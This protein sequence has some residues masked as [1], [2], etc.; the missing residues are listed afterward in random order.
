ME[1]PT[2][3]VLSALEAIAPGAVAQAA[4]TGSSSVPEPGTALILAP[5][6]QISIRLEYVLARLVAS[7]V[8]RGDSKLMIT[9]VNRVRSRM[10][11]EPGT[12]V[13]KIF[14]IQWEPTLFDGSPAAKAT[15][16]IIG[17][18]GRPRDVRVRPEFEL[19]VQFQRLKKDA[20]RWVSGDAFHVILLAPERER[21]EEGTAVEIGLAP[22][23]ELEEFNRLSEADPIPSLPHSI[24]RIGQRR[25]V[26]T[27]TH[28]E[29]RKFGKDKE[30]VTQ[31]F[32]G[33]Y[34]SVMM[35]MDPHSAPP[36]YVA[37]PKDEE[38]RPTIK[39]YKPN[40]ISYV[41]KGPKS[42]EVKFLGK[43]GDVPLDDG[44]VPTLAGTPDFDPWAALGHSPTRI[45]F[46]K[47]LELSNRL[48]A[49]VSDPENPAVAYG[50]RLGII[51]DRDDIGAIA[52]HV[53]QIV[54]RAVELAKEEGDRAWH[55]LCGHVDL[56]QTSLAEVL[57]GVEIEVVRKR[58]RGDDDP[59]AML[60]AQVIGTAF[61]WQCPM[62]RQLRVRLLKRLAREA[63][64]PEEPKADE[65][66]PEEP[67]PEG[68]G[69]SNGD[70]PPAP[71]T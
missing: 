61:D 59:A 5:K 43:P 35:F 66:P 65:K 26:W 11:R 39:A 16:R 67:K 29:E 25:M 52:T 15:L 12:K 47:L 71:A 63:N 41:L 14:R 1:N 40:V 64:P 3:E 2:Q 50:R 70:P 24:E 28:Y 21:D 9:K 19:D 4:L 48:N 37:G 45:D 51:R 42:C 31:I 34:G 18:D 69:S 23:S 33:Y 57:G 62:H 13:P 68:D 6:A 44:N 10:Y 58:R 36:D 54:A 17:Q 53:S 49:S 60:V 55:S 27:P 46:T 8:A 56:I 22:S 30:Q 20:G 7:K 32:L 38:G